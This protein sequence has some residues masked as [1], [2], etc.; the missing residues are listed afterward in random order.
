MSLFKELNRRNVFRVALAFLV[1]SWL[2]VQVAAT[3]EEALKLPDWFDAMAVSILLITFPVVL[4][5]SWAYEITPDG[6]KR[7]KHQGRFF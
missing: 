4:F 3:L 5:I 7:E 1:I 6:I 2:L